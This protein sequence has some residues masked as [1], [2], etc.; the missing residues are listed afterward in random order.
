MSEVTDLVVMSVGWA[1]VVTL[2]AVLAVYS[3]RSYRRTKARPMALLGA[4]FVILSAGTALAWFG[5]YFTF[6]TTAAVSIGCTVALAS[7][8]A[9]I[10]YALRTRFT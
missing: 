7:G 5:A 8:F 3:F 1:I 2:G 10:L 4:G 6:Y 9:L